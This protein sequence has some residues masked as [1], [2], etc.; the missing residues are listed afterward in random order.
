VTPPLPALSLRRNAAAWAVRN[1]DLPAAARVLLDAL[2]AEPFDPGF[3]GQD[4]TTTYFD[5]PDFALRKA[6]RKGR[7]YLTLRVRCYA[8]PGRADIYALSAKTEDQKWRMEIPDEEAAFLTASVNALPF[9]SQR[10]PPDL[11]ARLLDLLG[12][13]QALAAAVAVRARRYAVENARDRLTLDCDVSTDT[14]R[15]LPCAV[16]E[17]K[18]TQPDAEPPGGL[19]G[20]GLRPLKISKFLWAT[21]V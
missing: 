14:G 2:P 8:Q 18:S 9:L 11:Y 19:A 12:N 3:R 7:Q 13:G 16:L 10:L 1:R 4:L 6:R 21:E 5:A 15:R 17:F 20:L